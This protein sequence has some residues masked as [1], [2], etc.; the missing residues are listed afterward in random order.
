MKTF[1]LHTEQNAQALYAFLKANWKAMAE[2]GK[3]VAVCITEYKTRRSLEQNKMYWAT[4]K[5][6]A[7]EAWLGGRQYSADN[8][9]A[10]FAGEFIGW[11]DVP[12]NRSRP[13]STTGMSILEFSDYIEKVQHYAVEHLGVD[14]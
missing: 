12:G 1:V 2:V 5:Q 7:Q 4:L 9:H 8:W 3:P 11:E 14:I 10:F 13:I 6:I